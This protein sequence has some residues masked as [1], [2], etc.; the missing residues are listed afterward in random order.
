[1]LSKG[2]L[3]NP[4]AHN[5]LYCIQHKKRVLLL[6]GSLAQDFFMNQLPLAPEYP[7][8]LRPFQIFTKIRGDIHKFVFIARD[9]DIGDK[10]FTSVNDACNKL[11]PVLV[12]AIL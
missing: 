3:H 9:N 1:M 11:S 7:I 2:S 8:T 12:P 4:S 5:V 10:L 6:K